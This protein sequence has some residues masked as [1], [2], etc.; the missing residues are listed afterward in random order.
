M[1]S[2]IGSATSGAM[3]LERAGATA[4]VTIESARGDREAIR[5]ARLGFQSPRL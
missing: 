2:A 1:K 3:L 4:V 5:L